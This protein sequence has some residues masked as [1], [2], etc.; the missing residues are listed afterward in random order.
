MKKYIIAAVVAVVAFAMAGFAATLTVDGGVIQVGSDDDL[1][2]TDDVS[3][4]S[5]LIETD[6]VPSSFGVRFAD[7]SFDGCA[8]GNTVFVKVFNAD[9]TQIGRATS[10][11][12]AN[13]F[14]WAT[15]VPAESIERIEVI[16]EGSSS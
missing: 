10:T 11:V 3:V 15:P 4:A 9:D 6:G 7:G 16:L 5:Y 2:C 1:T 13:R 8:E 12:G 14:R